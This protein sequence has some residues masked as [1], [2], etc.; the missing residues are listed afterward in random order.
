[1]ANLFKTGIKGFTLVE[2]MVALVV[3]AILV[4]IAAPGFQGLI[5]R[6][7]LKAV[8]ETALSDLQVARSE[9]LTLGLSGAVTVSFIGGASW[10]YN[11]VSSGTTPTV[12]RKH[13]DYAGGITATVTGWVSSNTGVGFTISPVRSLNASGAGTITF[14]L[15]TLSVKIERNLLGGVFVCSANGDLGYRT[16]S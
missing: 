11:I 6:Q 16:C 3:M 9:A 10:E 13:S 5:E 14:A 8:V 2:L 7:R 12:T 15:E 4:A 1:M